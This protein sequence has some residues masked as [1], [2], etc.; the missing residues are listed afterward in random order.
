M[1]KYLLIL[2][3]ILAA[4]YFVKRGRGAVSP[5]LEPPKPR[6]K[7]P[8]TVASAGDV[9]ALYQVALQALNQN[10]PEEAMRLMGRVFLEASPNDAVML[11]GNLARTWLVEVRVP[12]P[13]KP[14]LKNLM[15][16]AIGAVGKQ[17][18]GRAFQLAM[19]AHNRAGDPENQPISGVLLFAGLRAAADTLPEPTID[20]LLE[21]AQRLME[22][23]P[24]G[25]LAVFGQACEVAPDDAGGWI[26]KAGILRA[27]GRHEEAIPA[28]DRALQLAPH[29]ADL[30]F[31]RAD[32]LECTDRLEEA[33][34]SYDGALARQPHMS[35]A[36][37]DRA[38]VLN[39][40]KRNPEALDSLV[41]GLEIHPDH[42]IG[43]SN[44]AEQ[45][46]LLG[47]PA[48]AVT[49]FERF[50]SLVVP[51][52]LAPQQ[53]RA[54]TMRA[55][56]L[57]HLG[58]FEE[59]LTALGAVGSLDAHL[60]W[61]RGSCLVS[62]GKPE[63]ALEALAVV[64]D[65]HPDVWIERGL[66]LERLKRVPEALEAYGHAS[67][68]SGRRWCHEARLRPEQA[69]EYYGRAVE[70]LLADDR[71]RRLDRL[72]GAELAYARKKLGELDPTYLAELET[73]TKPG[74]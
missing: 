65:D 73:A 5:V 21:Q 2:A 67:P 14:V 31:D 28:Y 60:T 47:H 30:W 45:E 16:Q 33:L 51:G 11:G 57:H 49:S 50:L 7:E 13:F 66:C 36:W 62:L 1:I 68:L 56:I 29:I 52:Q 64:P 58:R 20:E 46:L 70:A 39:R 37:V 12:P 38:H 26:G 53:E 48:E 72:R 32:S 15:E 4:I 71:V 3:V 42:A 27:V 55:V 24:T 41:H 61:L 54:R 18:F 40:L 44:R 74:S 69:A 25:A 6:A 22:T 35:N 23:D 17:D 34:A 19:D 59:A 10:R 8:A 43:W 63:A 9:Q